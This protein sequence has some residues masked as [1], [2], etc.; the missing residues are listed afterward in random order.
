TNAT[1]SVPNE[2]TAGWVR[3]VPY[4]DLSNFKNGRIAMVGR[5]TSALQFAIT[6]SA[7]GPLSLDL[8]YPNTNDGSL[9][10]AHVDLNGT[11]GKKLTID[12]DRGNQQLSVRDDV[13]GIA[14]VPTVTIVQPDPI[15]ITGARQDMHLNDEGHQVSVLFSRPVKIADGDDW[16]TKFHAQVLLNKDGVN[17]TGNRPMS[18]AALQGDSRVVNVTF[19]HA[20]S[21]NASYSLSVDAVIDPLTNV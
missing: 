19:D 2:A 14:A 17:Y 11:A 12:V 9:L 4:G 21:Q 10:R 16:L 18:A 20:L 6:P 3:N 7:S 13:G 8:I 5:W 15:K 1:M